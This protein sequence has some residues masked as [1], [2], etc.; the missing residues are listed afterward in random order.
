[1]GL[2]AAVRTNMQQ[3]QHSFSSSLLASGTEVV[4]Y[5]AA[6]FPVP[7]STSPSLPSNSY[8]NSPNPY[9]SPV[10]GS[11]AVVDWNPLHCSSFSFVGN[12]ELVSSF[13]FVSDWWFIAKYLSSVVKKLNLTTTENKDSSYSSSL[14]TT[15]S[16]SGVYKNAPKSFSS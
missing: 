3:F 10:T 2:D 8:T 5:N 7:F 11:G 6:G 9:D 13:K 16:S 4:R 12:E 14:L 15:T 1:M